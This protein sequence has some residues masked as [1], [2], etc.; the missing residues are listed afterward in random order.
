MGFLITLFLAIVFGAL[1]L[2]RPKLGLYILVGLIVSFD[3]VGLGFT[4]FRGSWVFNAYFVGFYGLRLIEVLTVSLYIPFLLTLKRLP[5]KEK[6]FAIERNLAVLMIVWCAMLTALEYYYTK[7]VEVGTWRLMVSGMMQFHLMVRLFKS[8]DERKQLLKFMLIMLTL[9]AFVGLA[10]Y[11]AGYGVHSFRGRVPFFYDSVQIEAFALGAVILWS[12]LLN[13]N[14]QKKEDRLFSKF[15]VFVMMIIL[16]AAVVGSIRRTIWVTTASGLLLVLIMSRRTTIMHYFAVLLVGATTIAALLLAPGL[17]DFR[18]H[19]GKYV[20]S[21]N[22]LSEDQLSG[23]VENEVHFN[24]VES[25]SRL[26]LENPDIVLVGVHGPASKNYRELIASYSEDG[27]PLGLAHNGPIRSIMSFGVMGLI[28]YFCLFFAVIRRTLTVHNAQLDENVLNQAA[29]ACGILLFL[30]FCATMLFVP[31]FYTSSK[32]LF[33]TFFGLFMLE[34]AASAVRATTT[35]K[36]K[37]V[38]Y[39]PDGTVVQPALATEVRR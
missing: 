6:P 18:T 38:R 7:K 30:E 31:P 24:N 11:A 2:T 28:A 16:L 39:N 9:R 15:V 19:M 13:G 27:S 17:E 4:T 29:I 1:G 23:N 34:T 12:F 22:L 21:M 35:A 26:L 25:Y 32:G 14:S 5:A 37:K 36:K 20:Q 33:Y 10:M 3:E 8:D